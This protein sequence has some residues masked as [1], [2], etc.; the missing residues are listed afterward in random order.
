M[1]KFLEP[2]EP[3]EVLNT[4]NFSSF[5]YDATGL[6][7]EYNG[8]KKPFVVS[9]KLNGENDIEILQK[10][11]N[12]GW[13][14]AIKTKDIYSWQSGAKDSRQIWLTIPNNK[15]G[16]IEIDEMIQSLNQIKSQIEKRGVV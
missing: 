9:A 10:K 15:H 12:S 1:S 2:I 11:D 8:V 14:L 6:Y 4:V 5:M 7:T 13:A 3:I 16:I